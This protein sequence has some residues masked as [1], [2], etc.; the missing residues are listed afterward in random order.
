MNRIIQNGLETR[1]MD[2][3][4][5]Q[6]KKGFSLVE[7]MVGSSILT[8]VLAG[9]FSGLG[10]ALCISEVVQSSNFAAQLRSAALAKRNGRNPPAA[11]GRGGKPAGQR[12]FRSSKELFHCTFAGLLLHE[13]C[14]VEGNLSKR[15]SSYRG[16]DGFEGETPLQRICHLLHE[17]GAF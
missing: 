9:A 16:M 11:M 15:N 17:G 13:D 7:L 6:D 1:R 5:T 12:F 10:Q 2:R 4:P 14:F 3:R 8:L